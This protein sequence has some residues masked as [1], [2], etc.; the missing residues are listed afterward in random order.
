VIYDTQEDRFIVLFL[1]GTTHE[2]TALI[3]AFSQTSDPS[4][5]WNV[6]T[7]NGN[8][9]NDDTW[10]DFPTLAVSSNDVWITTNSYYN[11]SA[12]NSGKKQ[13]LIWRVSKP[14]GFNGTPLDI[15][16][17]DNLKFNNTYL[18]SLTPS[19]NHF[20]NA[21][22]VLFLSNDALLGGDRFYIAQLSDDKINIR[23]ISAGVPYQLPP[24]ARQKEHDRKLNTNDSR[25]LDAVTIGDDI[26]FVLNT[27]DQ[28]FHA[29]VY[30]GIVKAA[31]T[32]GET[33]DALIISDE[34]DIAFP[35]ITKVA[36]D[37]G[38]LVMMLYLHASPDHFPG[39]SAL[40]LRPMENGIAL[41]E[42]LRIQ[43][44]QHPLAYWGDYTKIVAAPDEPGA[45]WISGSFGLAEGPVTLESATVIGKI[46]TS[47]VTSTEDKSN[48]ATGLYPN[49]VKTGFTLNMTGKNT[50][51][52]R[53]R[54]V[55]SNNQVVF[56]STEEI[57]SPGAY[58][59]FMNTDFLSDGLYMLLIGDGSQVISTEKFVVAK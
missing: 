15:N 49:P 47:A 19:T 58:S 50:G 53:I 57:R 44:G 48:P 10:S 24:D 55:N 56:E 17:Y 1:A 51:T 34:V 31:G 6:Y 4:A 41:S 54:I 39:C 59:F 9:L 5:L 52:I 33:I 29:A 25:I 37:G 40:A 28:E 16:V 38:E 20:D 46:T 35:S 8:P 45:A 21:Q 26:H 18:F 30:Y 2:T 7:L 13:S 12:N 3:L 11:G 43:Q 32:P 22:P 23:Q 14:G 42:P 27:A 36:A